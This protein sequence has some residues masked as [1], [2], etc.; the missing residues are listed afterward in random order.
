MPKEIKDGLIPIEIMKELKTKLDLVNEDNLHVSVLISGK[1]TRDATCST[2][3]PAQLAAFMMH[4]ALNTD[5][6]KLSIS[7][8]IKPN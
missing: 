6:A 1:N 4:L 5:N 2:M 8:L 3:N 7:E